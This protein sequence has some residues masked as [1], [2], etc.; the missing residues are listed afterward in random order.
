MIGVGREHT[1]QIVIGLNAF[2]LHIIKPILI[3]LPHIQ[4]GTSDGFAFDIA[5]GAGDQQR[6]ALAIKADVCTIGYHGASDTWKG[7]FGL[8]HWR[9]HLRTIPVRCP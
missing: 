1:A 9:V 3:G 6:C 5:H 8:N 7:A 2:F 4:R